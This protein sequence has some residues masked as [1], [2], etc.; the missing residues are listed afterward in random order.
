[1]SYFYEHEYCSEMLLLDNLYSLF[2]HFALI[3]KSRS[4]I[5]CICLQ[6][7]KFHIVYYFLSSHC[8]FPIFLISFLN[9]LVSVSFTH[10]QSIFLSYIQSTFL[11]LTHA[12]SL[13][14]LSLIVSVS[15][16]TAVSKQGRSREINHCPFVR[17]GLTSVFA[18]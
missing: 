3:Q 15:L 11:S 13:F 9:F 2:S 5:Q 17:F 18:S 7:T 12:Q 10:S 14:S 8:F 6:L 16:S 4:W 1:M